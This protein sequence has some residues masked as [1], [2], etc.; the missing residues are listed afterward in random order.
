MSLQPCALLAVLLALI[1]ATNGPGFAQSVPAIMDVPKNVPATWRERLEAERASLAKEREEIREKA[2]AH[3]KRCVDVDAETPLASSCIASQTELQNRILAYGGR[4][5]KYNEHATQAAVIRFAE[6]Q[7]WDADELKRIKTAL[8][9]LPAKLDDV[10]QDDIFEVWGNIHSRSQQGRFAQMASLGAGPVLVSSG[11]QAGFNDCAVFALANT[12]GRPYGVVASVAAEILRGA[13]WRTT[14][15]RD[16]PQHTIETTGLNG[17]EVILL[18]EAFGQVKVV[19]DQEFVNVLEGGDAIM[20][21]VVPE[22]LGSGHETVISKTFEYDG[23][24][25]FEMMDSREGQLRRLYLTEKEL[26]TIILENGIVFYPDSKTVP[27]LLRQGNS[28]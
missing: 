17:G 28:Q 14:G 24:T 15:E 9:K 21:N 13:A 27:K 19:T 7:G 16:N 10:L 11:E 25:W 5:R 6:E 2:A 12:T 22:E 4:V 3:N 1:F 23:A 20:V 26:K 8:D 18:A